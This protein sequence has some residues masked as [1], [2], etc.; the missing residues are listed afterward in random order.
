MTPREAERVMAQAIETFGEVTQ[1]IV[2]AEECSELAV[3]C[4]HKVRYRTVPDAEII[5]EIADV[6]IMLDQ[7]TMMLG[8]FASVEVEKARE[9]KLLRLAGRIRGSS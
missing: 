6:S 8:P 3:K 9:K 5:E 1:W 4:L 7:A 2:V